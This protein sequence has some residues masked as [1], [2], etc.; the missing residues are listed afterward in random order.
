MALPLKPGYHFNLDRTTR[1]SYYEMNAAEAYTDYYGISYMVSGERLIYSPSFTTIV[2]AGEV[3]FIPKNLYRRTTYLSDT[4]YERIL[5]KFTDDM[6]SDLLAVIGKDRFDSLCTEHIL[7]F[8]PD[9]SKKIL[10]IIEEM[11]QEWN[12]YNEYSEL[13]LKGLLNK[14]IILCL[15]ERILTN[16]HDLAAEK[17]QDYLIDAITYIKVHLRD[18]PSL[19]ETARHI[20]ISGSYLSKIFVNRLYTPYSTFVLN[21]KISYAR[22]L[23]VETNLSMTAIADASGFSGSAYFSDC[24]KRNTGQTPMQFRKANKTKRS[25]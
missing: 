13:L 20:N 11:E 17:Q 16:N 8:T 15:K 23:L 5:I 9:T 12:T 1:P 25:K 18:T 21:E 3:V 14:L 24:F 22:K 19:Q 2:Q 6:I 4:P 10:A 7:R